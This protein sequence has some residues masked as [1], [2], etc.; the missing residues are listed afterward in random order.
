MC[1][2]SVVGQF[3]PRVP[4]GYVFQKLTDDLRESAAVQYALPIVEPPHALCT[5]M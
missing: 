2:Q 3:R 4:G 5:C 1:M